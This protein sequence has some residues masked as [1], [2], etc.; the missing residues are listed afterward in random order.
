[1][2]GLALAPR[3]IRETFSTSRLLE[4][5]SKKEL[6]ASIGHGVED[7]PV[8]VVK[9]LIDNAIDACEENGIAPVVEIEVSTKPGEI[10]VTDN[11]PGI[12][13]ETVDAILDYT[14]RVSS[15]EAYVSPTRGQQGNAMK[16]IIAMPFALADGAAG[17][18]MIE[19]RGIAHRIRFS[20]DPIRQEPRIACDRSTSTVRTGTRVTVPMAC[21]H[22]EQTMAR[23]LPFVWDFAGLNPHLA[24]TL[25][26]DGERLITCDEP[27]DPAWKKWVPSDPIPPHWYTPETLQRLIAASVHRD[28]EH[29]DP[30]RTVRDFIGGFRGLA[31]TAKR[32][33]VLRAA[34]LFRAP[35]D[36]FFDGDRVDHAGIARLLSAMQ[37]HTRPV[38]PEALGLIGE[39]HFRRV[40]TWDEADQARFKYCRILGEDRG[41]PFVVEAAFAPATEQSSTPLVSGI[42]WSAAIRSPFPNLSAELHQQHVYF[43]T[44]PLLVGIHLA[45]PTVQFVDRGKSMAARNTAGEVAVIKAIGR[46]TKDWS[47]SW[48]RRQREAWRRN[49]SV[50]QQIEQRAKDARARARRERAVT[51]G[52][53]VLHAEIAA[54]AEVTG[55][56]INALTVL[57]V[58][59]DPYRRDTT[60]GHRDGKWFADQV[61]RFVPADRQVH[62]RGLFYRIVVAADVKRP[63][64]SPFINDLDCWIWLQNKASKAARWLGYVPFERIRDERNEAPRLISYAPPASPGYG[65]LTT[66][67]AVELPEI[68]DLLP[69][70]SGSA[71]VVAQPYRIILVG[72][73]SS[74]GEVLEPIAQEVRGELLLPTGEISDTMLSEMAARAAADPRPSVVL[75]FSD[76]D[77]SGRQ[78]PIS[79]SRKLQALRTLHHPDL[80]IQVHQAALTIEQVTLLK[81]PSTPLKTTERRAAKWRERMGHEQVEI[82]ALV[83]LKPGELQ[84]IARAAVAP[85]FDFDL[86]RRCYDRFLEWRIEAEKRLANHP[87]RAAAEANIKQAAADVKAA[88]AELVRVQ[89][90]AVTKLQEGDD[91]I[92]EAEI[93]TPEAVPIEAEAPAPLFRTDDDFVTATLRLIASKAMDDVEEEGAP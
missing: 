39:D 93:P 27:T 50:E 42:N 32:S 49:R 76:F 89:D 53:G 52:S 63:D 11:G 18:T 1:M 75:Y 72:E 43:A 3:L 12:P 69:R 28:L 31:G 23:F 80:Q 13:P 47:D 65:L 55:D 90:E 68:G 86:D 33:E 29:G 40:F 46:V 56:S 41:L 34:D 10:V 6:V 66:E 71:P 37:T 8:Y 57:S 26:W 59:N 30:V 85:F 84:Q 67:F 70:L 9:E 44:S 36:V 64:G 35:L 38:K 45:S 14:V 51:V 61:E 91:G 25:E 48:E 17:E 78:M 24:I 21:H 16:T 82:D 88:V 81:L 54:A 73:K 74:L 20:A 22:L 58:T 92:P 60:D 83:E 2:T 4:F 62:L 87:A 7:W 19:A 15:R 79:V 5:C 77:P